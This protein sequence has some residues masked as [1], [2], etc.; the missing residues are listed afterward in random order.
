[1]KMFLRGRPIP[2]FVPDA[3]VAT[4]SLDVKLELPHKK[5]KLDWVYPAHGW[6]PRG[7]G[8]LGPKLWLQASWQRPLALSLDPWPSLQVRVSGP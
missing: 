6:V 4:Y 5:L 3:V 2:M 7:R 8:R 1:M